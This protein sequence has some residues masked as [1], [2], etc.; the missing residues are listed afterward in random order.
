MRYLVLFFLLIAQ[1]LLAAQTVT[2]KEGTTNFG[3]VAVSGLHRFAN[4]SIDRWSNPA[5]TLSGV[6]QYS[7]DGGK[8]YLDLIKFT[9]VGSSSIEGIAAGR[10]LPPGTTHIKGSI[11]LVGGSITLSRQAT[12]ESR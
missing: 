4:F 12:F 8:I 2:I 9:A 11:T 7:T 6:V 3:P 10:S 1:P 5:I